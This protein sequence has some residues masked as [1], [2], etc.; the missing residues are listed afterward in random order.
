MNYSTLIKPTYRDTDQMGVVYHANYLVYFEVARTEMLRNMGYEYRKLENMGI[1]LPVLECRVKYIKPAV[2]D[3]EVEVSCK[4]SYFKGIRMRI[5]YEM[6]SKESGE[7]LAIGETEHAFVSKDMKPV[8][9]SKV[10]PKL[11]E[12]LKDSMIK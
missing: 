1:I 8:K 5:E 4:V 2:Y 6:K 9:I 3:D 11:V 7:L 10:D 12:K